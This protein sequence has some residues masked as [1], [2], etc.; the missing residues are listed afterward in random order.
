MG[1]SSSF[2]YARTTDTTRKPSPIIWNLVDVQALAM[3]ID[4]YLF[5]D[6]FHDLPTG[7]YT[8]T[9]A[10]TGTFALGDGEGG[11][12]LADCDS[13]TVVQGI[14]VQLGGTAGEMFSIPDNGLCLFEARLKAADIATGP[15]FFFG[16]AETD[17]TIIASSAMSS[18]T[19][20]VGFK[21]VTDDGVILGCSNDAAESTASSIHTFV[22]DAYVK[23]G[24]VIKNGS[25]VQFF[26]NGALKANTITTAAN[27][28]ANLL[29][30]S[31][32]CQ[33]SGT[34]DPIVHVDW[35]RFAVFNGAL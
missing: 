26:V 32:V 24:C 29:R 28:P 10:T 19:E 23:L 9:Q 35:W 13:T 18:A 30:P 25:L 33:S 15:E 20:Y 27:I 8:A 2:D 16:L 21:S 17:T 31:L 3:G 22:D 6:D 4:G 11:V 12:V 1:A 14:N 7:K 5:H 34:T